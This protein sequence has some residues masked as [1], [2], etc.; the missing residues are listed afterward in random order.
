MAVDFRTGLA[1]STSIT[2]TLTSLANNASRESAAV[3]NSTNKYD[4]ADVYVACKLL[5]GTPANELAIYV[6]LA[7]SEDGTN[8]T[9]NATG[10]DAGITLRTPTNLNLLGVIKTP[11][12]GALTYK[13]VFNTRNVID[14]LP[15]KWS[16]VV[17]NKT[18]LA[19]DTTGNAMSYTG[20][21]STMV[22]S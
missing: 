13:Q 22:T 4:M 14:R 10:A 15:R 18:N 21:Y 6:W 9:D 1:T 20:K 11:D 12:S 7:L 2:I 8:Y 17:T 5:T 19:F 3:D 16:V